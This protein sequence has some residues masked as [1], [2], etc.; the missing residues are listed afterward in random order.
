MEDYPSS[1]G[2]DYISVNNNPSKKVNIKMN[3]DLWKKDWNN[4][5]KEDLLMKEQIKETMY[6]NFH[7]DENEKMKLQTEFGMILF[8]VSK[9]SRLSYRASKIINFAWKF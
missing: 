8:R 9:V 5:M 4:E 7:Q 1:K 6:I 2:E 3:E